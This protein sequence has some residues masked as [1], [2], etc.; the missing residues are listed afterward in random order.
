MI[1]S[2]SYPCSTAWIFY[3]HPFH[4][5]KQNGNESKQNGKQTMLQVEMLQ[6]ESKFKVPFMRFKVGTKKG[7]ALLQLPKQ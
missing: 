2:N 1:E 6:V 5:S 7:A 3:F 4:S